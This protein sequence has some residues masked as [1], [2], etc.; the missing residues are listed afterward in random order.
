MR[1]HFTI[2]ET[3]QWSWILKRKREKERRTET[4]RRIL[5]VFGE[6]CLHLLYYSCF[7]TLIF[8]VSA[9]TANEESP[10]ENAEKGTI[11]AMWESKIEKEGKQNRKRD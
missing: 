9:N 2:I 10:K 11:Y 3:I 4:V 1:C 7:K 8:P 5:A 6:H